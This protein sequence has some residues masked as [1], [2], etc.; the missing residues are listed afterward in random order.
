MPIFEYK[1]PQCGFINEVLV[2]SS[3]TLAP[4]C[5]QCGHKKTE[6]QFSSFTPVVKQTPSSRPAKCH[7][8]PSAG[9]CPSFEK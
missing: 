3:D 4:A 2:K 9:S 7:S 5:P 1:C 6:K 8:C